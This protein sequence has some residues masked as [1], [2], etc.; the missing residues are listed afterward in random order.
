MAISKK[1]ELACHEFLIDLNWSKAMQRAG[2]KESSARNSGNRYF[3]RP[4]VQALIDELMAQRKERIK[5]DGDDVI[6]ELECVAYSNI[7][8]L[9]EYEVEDEAD[10]NESKA[11]IL[12]DLSGLPCSVTAAIRDIK[13]T[14]ASS[15]S[16]GKIEIKLHNKLSALEAL[17]R[18][19]QLFDKGAD[20]GIEF[21]MHMDLGGG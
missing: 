2:Y 3:A 11:L 16:P 4:E 21:H 8:D 12:R 5:R 7:M 9:F 17:G 1:L 10:L 20:Q 18:H 19:F 6:K 14:P 15:Q 13:I